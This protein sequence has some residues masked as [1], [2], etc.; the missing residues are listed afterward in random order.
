MQSW[1]QI[2]INKSNASLITQ[3]PT[4][5]KLVYSKTISILIADNEEAIRDSLNMVLE[6]EG[7]RCTVV[8]DG[9]EAI[10]VVQSKRFDLII[11]DLIMPEMSG[12]QVLRKLKEIKPDTP[13]LIMSS[14]FDWDL[15]AQAMSLGALHYLIKPI[16]FE[17]LIHYLKEHF[18]K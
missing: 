8:Q 7:Y 11:L 10:K 3:I 9:K 5:T 14:Y 18:S 17:E 4:G 16:D 13:V 1:Y 6:D 2:C 12:I 15:A